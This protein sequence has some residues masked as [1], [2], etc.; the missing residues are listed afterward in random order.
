VKRYYPYII[1]EEPTSPRHF[2]QIDDIE[3]VKYLGRNSYFVSMA[4]GNS[5]ILIIE[6]GHSATAYQIFKRHGTVQN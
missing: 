4:Q 5:Y 2:G 1:D 3:S 6:K